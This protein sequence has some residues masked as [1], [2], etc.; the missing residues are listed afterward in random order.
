VCVFVALGVQHAM[1]MH[2][3]VICGLSAPT[4][5]FYII[6]LKVKLKKIL[7]IQCVLGFS[8]QILSATLL[9]LRRIQGDIIINVHSS[10]CKVPVIL[11]RFQ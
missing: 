10:S 4:A 3:F 6:S 11:F 1:L 2:H 8:L 7:N 9:I 5:F